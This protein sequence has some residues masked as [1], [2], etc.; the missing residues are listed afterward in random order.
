MRDSL[1]Q[2]HQQLKHRLPHSRSVAQLGEAVAEILASEH[3]RRLVPDGL[4][5]AVWAAGYGE[6]QGQQQ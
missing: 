4:A 5:P 1:L 6:R 3:Y 2:A